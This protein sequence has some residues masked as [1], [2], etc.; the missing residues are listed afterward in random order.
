MTE[1]FE[2]GWIDQAIV[3]WQRSGYRIDGAKFAG[4]PN[5]H[6]GLEVLGRAVARLADV[7]VAVTCRDSDLTGA[8]WVALPLQRIPVVPYASV[9]APLAAADVMAIP[10]LESEVTRYQM[11]MKVFDA[12]IGQIG[13]SLCDIVRD[14]SARPVTSPSDHPATKSIDGTDLLSPERT[15]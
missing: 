15:V 6:K 2:P 7:R 8:S 1:A 12:T 5:P 4:T 11:P 3:A 13:H 9:P 14:V 10:Q